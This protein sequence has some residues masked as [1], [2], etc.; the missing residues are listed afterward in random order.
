MPY[1]RRPDEQYLTLPV[2]RHKC[3]IA[4]E[5]NLLRRTK[6]NNRITNYSYSSEECHYP[7]LISCCQFTILS[8]IIII[9]ERFRRSISQGSLIS[10]LQCLHVEEVNTTQSRCQSNVHCTHTYFASYS[11]EISFSVGERHFVRHLGSRQ[12]FPDTL[13]I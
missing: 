13:S 8:F 1:L 12:A 2:E 11:A 7:L 4:R 9:V 10:A 6:Q 5:T 3:N